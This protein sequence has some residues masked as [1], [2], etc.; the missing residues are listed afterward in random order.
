M[1]KAR[2]RERA[3][4]KAAQNIKNGNVGKRPPSDEAAA[5]KHT[6]GQFDPGQ[7]AITKPGSTVNTRNFSES[8]RGAS[9][10]R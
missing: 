4:A 10:S 5:P 9:R 6:Q 1:T 3:K 8:R 2:A 7:G